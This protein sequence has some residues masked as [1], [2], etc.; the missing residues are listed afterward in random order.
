MAAADIHHP[1]AGLQ[2]F[3]DPGQS[4]DPAVDQIHR[5]AGAEET[6]GAAETAGRTIAPAKPLPIANRLGRFLLAVINGL[7]RLEETRKA[8]RSALGREHQ[9]LSWQEAERPA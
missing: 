3:L 6:V 8:P 5:I 9:R 7:H 1:C 2:L 4:G